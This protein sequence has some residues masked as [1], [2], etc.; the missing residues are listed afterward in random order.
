[1]QKDVKAS[2]FSSIVGG[3]YTT[4]G[5]MQ[6]IAFSKESIPRL[7]TWGVFAFVVGV[8]LIWWM[9]DPKYEGS[10]RVVYAQYARKSFQLKYAMDEPFR[11]IVRQD[12]SIIHTKDAIFNIFTYNYELTITGE[13]IDDS[14]Y[15]DG[16][17][18]GRWPDGAKIYR[19]LMKDTYLG[20]GVATYLTDP[21]SFGPPRQ[22]S[23][24]VSVLTGPSPRGTTSIYVGTGLDFIEQQYGD[25][26]NDE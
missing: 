13:V 26:Q 20:D 3:P 6:L 9:A 21:D 11:S 22:F 7:L 5:T 23:P 2:S 10:V 4:F 12:E 19:D 14:L 24:G 1:M 17:L 18:V 25:Y 15:F 8:L 16:E